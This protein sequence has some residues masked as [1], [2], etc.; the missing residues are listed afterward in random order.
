MNWSRNTKGTKPEHN[1]T[2]DE[3]EELK[4]LLFSTIQQTK[5]D[6][7]A[8]SKL[9]RVHHLNRESCLKKC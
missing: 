6:Y 4:A 5:L 7:D 8:K 2:E 1:A 3:V 9:P